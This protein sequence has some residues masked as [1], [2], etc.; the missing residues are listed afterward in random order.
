MGLTPF[1]EIVRH[2]ANQVAFSCDDLFRE[3][4]EV[5]DGAKG[6]LRISAGPGWSY[7]IVPEA[8]RRMHIIAPGVLVECSTELVTE[9]I[10]E[11]RLGNV[12]IV[13]N[14]LRTP[15]DPD[16]DLVHQTLLTINHFIFAG[17]HHP[18]RA[19]KDLSLSDLA[20]YPWISFRNSVE[21]RQAIRELFENLGLRPPEPTVVTNSYQTCLS[22]LQAGNYLMVL[23]SSLHSLAQQQGVS[24]LPV[25]V[26]LGSFPAGLT[27]RRSAMRL[28][29]FNRLKAALEE[30]VQEQDF[31]EKS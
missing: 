15:V 1:G 30:V 8:I 14:R 3:V 25:D 27:Y 4:Q 18:L 26:R 2:H 24:V 10:Q 31:V 5:V 23:P 22:L 7:S 19:Q 17:Q 28:T 11:L 21:A 20:A 16:E 29:Y 9:S 6:T 13:I 12:D